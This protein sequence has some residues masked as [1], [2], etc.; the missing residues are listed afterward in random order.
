MASGDIDPTISNI[1][2]DEI[3]EGLLKLERHEVTG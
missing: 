1:T 3:W 2:F